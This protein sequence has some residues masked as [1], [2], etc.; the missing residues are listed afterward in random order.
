MAGELPI[1]ASKL[2]VPRIIKAYC[3]T[4]QAETDHIIYKHRDELYI[5]CVRCDEKKIYA[6]NKAIL[7][8][9]RMFCG[10]CGRETL[11]VLYCTCEGLFCDNEMYFKCIGCGTKRYAGNGCPV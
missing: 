5:K 8:F 4:C 1:L 10:T 3:N 11:W 9:E 7:A 6:G 2:A